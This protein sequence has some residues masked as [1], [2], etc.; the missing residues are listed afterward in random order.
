MIFAVSWGSSR[1]NAQPTDSE[2]EVRERIEQAFQEGGAEQLLTPAAERVELGILG[3]QTYYS[4][5]QA[6]YVLQDFFKN[7]PPREF[8]IEDESRAEGDFFLTAQYWYGQA[9]QP[10]QVYV[11]LTQQEEE[12]WM[13]QEVRL[14]RNDR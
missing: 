5:N 11:R 14:D 12:Q 4:R 6:L 7:Y 8:S 10:L 3:M 2:I 13:L 9:E 1:T